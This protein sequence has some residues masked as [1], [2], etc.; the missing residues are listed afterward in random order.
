M[1]PPIST[2]ESASQ[3]NS[4]TAV[5]H[6]TA[7][8]PHGDYTVASFDPVQLKQ[9]YDRYPD[10][11]EEEQDL[12]LWIEGAEQTYVPFIPTSSR[13]VLVALEMARLSPA[14]KVLDV[15]SGDGRF[16][17]A[18]VKF[19]NAQKAIGIEYEQDLVDKSTELAQEYVDQERVLFQRANLTNWR[20]LSTMQSKEWTVIVV[21]L[22]PEGGSDMEDWLVQEFERGVRI[23]ALVF[24]LK[25]LKG[26]HCSVED[27]QESVW[28]YEKK[29]EDS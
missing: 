3:I 4:M 23:I 29:Q 22:S 7:T 13:R 26:L 27:K 19:F 14:D 10:Y 12:P 17:Y 25:H 20:E 8:A 9:F 24:D 2:V 28:I 5:K 18:A 15:G 11:S 16:C 21:F 1:T 6:S